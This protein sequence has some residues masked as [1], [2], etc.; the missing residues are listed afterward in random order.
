MRIERG[1]KGTNYTISFHLL[2][3]LSL[4]TVPRLLYR[5]SHR[6]YCRPY[7]VNTPSIHRPCTIPHLGMLMAVVDMVESNVVEEGG[8][9]C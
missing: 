2:S 8:R 4:C 9:T 7:T 1:K 3:S 5:S 6:P